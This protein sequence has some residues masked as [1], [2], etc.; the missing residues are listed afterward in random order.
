M[1]GRGAVTG[2]GGLV[3]AAGGNDSEAGEK[4]GETEAHDDLH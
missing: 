4:G 3:A 2:C 1:V